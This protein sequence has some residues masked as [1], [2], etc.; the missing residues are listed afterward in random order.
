MATANE[1]GIEVGRTYESRPGSRS[2]PRE[3]IWVS[4]LGD[5]VQY[6]G[7]AVKLGSRYPQV[8]ADAFAKWAGL[9][10]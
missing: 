9:S 8:S 4:A 10:A 1:Y 3:V 7:P 5:T 2:A 6:D